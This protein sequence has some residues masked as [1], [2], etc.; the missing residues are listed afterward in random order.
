MRTFTL[1][2]ASFLFGHIIARLFIQMQWNFLAA[3]PVLILGGAVIGIS[4]NYLW[5]REEK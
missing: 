4:W 2:I 5:P 1:L 3:L